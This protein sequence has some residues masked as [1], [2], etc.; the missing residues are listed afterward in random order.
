M[1]GTKPDAKLFGE[2]AVFDALPATALHLGA[3]R[4]FMVERLTQIGSAFLLR[5]RYHC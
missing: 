2:V 5:R 1:G 3:L 4:G